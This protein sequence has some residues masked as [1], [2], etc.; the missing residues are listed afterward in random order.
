MASVDHVLVLLPRAA[1]GGKYVRD[2]LIIRPP[3]G[4]LYVL[5]RR[6]H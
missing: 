6:A 5:L 3:L 1:L 2:G 4:A